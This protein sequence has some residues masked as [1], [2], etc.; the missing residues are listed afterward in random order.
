M[1][2]KRC[3]NEDESYFY[4]GKAGTYCRKCIPFKRLMIEEEPAP[5]DYDI[6]GD[7]DYELGF[8]LTRFQKEA[9]RKCVE[10]LKEKNVL[11]EAVCGAGKSEIMVEAMA[12]YLKEGKKVCLE[13]A[14]VEVV[15]EL[16]IR[17]Q[18]I[19]H[20]LKV[21]SVYGGHSAVI[22]GDLIICTIHQLY[23]YYQSFDLLVIDEVDAF[24]LKDNLTLMNIAISSAR[25]RIIFSTAT[26]SPF[27]LSVLKKGDYG[28]VKLLVRPS[29]VPMVLPKVYYLPWLILLMRL[30]VI[31]KKTKRQ[32]IIFTERKMTAKVLYHLCKN[33]FSCTYVYSDL[34][35]RNENINDFRKG[36][37]QFIFSTAVLER[38]ITIKGV[39][40]A[41]LIR[42]KS[43]DQGSIVQMVGRV[44]R[45]VEDLGGEAYILATSYHQDIKKAIDYLKEANRELEMSLL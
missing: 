45:D 20:K 4:H 33:F 3:G 18:R 17:Y 34:P 16:A 5:I 38:G 42:Y 6:K 32:M 39:E 10:Y 40:V 28:H 29:L 8:E 22:S 36:K 37:Y 44:G 15:K 43:F 7:G 23:R 31:M 41:L 12:S 11:L 21:V 14:R 13:I 35:E 25:G 24:P 26:V 1:R 30:I 2:C 9:S 19:F 27:I